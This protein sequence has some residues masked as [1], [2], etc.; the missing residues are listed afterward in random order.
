MVSSDSGPLRLSMLYSVE[1]DAGGG[2]GGAADVADVADVA[3][4]PGS[5]P[6]RG[7]QTHLRGTLSV[8]SVAR[9]FYRQQELWRLLVPL[10]RH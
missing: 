8:V 6:P 5:S 1:V 9:G 4:P 7:V 3:A 2:G 10:A